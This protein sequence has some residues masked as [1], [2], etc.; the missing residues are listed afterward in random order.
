LLVSLLTV[1]HILSPPWA[2]GRL[3]WPNSETGDMPASMCETGNINT[4][5]ERHSQGGYTLVLSLFLLKTVRN[6]G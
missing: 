1:V 3:F 6:R 5:K 2:L 4:E